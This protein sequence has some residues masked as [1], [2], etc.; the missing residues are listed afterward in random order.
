MKNTSA[1]LATLFMG[2][3][4]ALNNPQ[5]AMAE[6]PETNKLIDVYFGS[7]CFWHIM[8]EFVGAE[9]KYLSRSDKELTSL[10]GYAGGKDTSDKVCYH[11][12]SGLPDYG[13]L[14]H[15]EVVGMKIPESAYANFATDFFALLDKNGDRP[16]KGDRGSE[17]RSLVGLPGG[18]NSPLIASLQKAGGSKVQFTA[19]KGNDPD[20]LGK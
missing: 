18:M 6:T 10:A 8:H 16:D 5:P 2:A 20:T 14:G 17:Y 15:G 11:N 9:R 12:F 19:G 4:V 3:N 13:K 1:L 7:G